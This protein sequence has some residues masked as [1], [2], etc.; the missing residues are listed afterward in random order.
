MWRRFSTV[1]NP[2]ARLRE[3]KKHILRLYKH[4]HPDRLGRFPQ[5]RK[6][7]EHSFQVLQSAIDRHFDRFQARAN[8]PPEAPKSSKELIFYAHQV[9]SRHDCGT[10]ELTKAVISLH[11]SR[12]GHALASLFDELGLEPPPKSVLPVTGIDRDGV[13]FMSLRELVKYARQVEMESIQTR[14]QEAATAAQRAVDEEV[15]VTRLA[16]QRSRGFTIVLGT[17]LPVKLERLFRRLNRTVRKLQEVDLRTV[18]I[19]LD[20]GFHVEVNT[21]GSFPFVSLGA[22]ASEDTWIETLRSEE[23]RTAARAS[24]RLVTELHGL[25]AALAGALGVR[26]VMH[27]IHLVDGADWESGSDVRQTKGN[28]LEA[29]L[30]GTESLEA[31]RN[32]LQSFIKSI[33]K[34]TVPMFVHEARSLALMFTDGHGFQIDLEQGVLRIGINDDQRKIAATLRAHGQYVS[35]EYEM[36]KLHAEK[37]EKRLSNVRRSLGIPSLRRLQEVSDREWHTALTE[38]RADASKLRGVLDGTPLVIGTRARMLTDT[39]EI[40]IPFDYRQWLPI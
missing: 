33:E 40:E 36:K 20:G 22:C 38:L 2:E 26:L 15:L 9:K 39:G 37:E 18:V 10:N 14:G 5:E 8:T 16:L 35:R 11:E 29:L 25:E 28:N 30:S 34:E 21:N 1:F 27:N 3:L 24:Q 13:E 32:L 17:G 23:I 7:N 19:E 12:L 6:V 31:Y 4:I